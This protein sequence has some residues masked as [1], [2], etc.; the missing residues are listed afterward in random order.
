MLSKVSCIIRASIKMIGFLAW[1]LLCALLQIPVMLLS[2]NRTSYV[3]PRLY[4]QGVCK[5]LN[6]KTQIIGTISTEKRLYLSNHLSYLDVPV[7]GSLIPFVSFVAK[8][9]VESWPAFGA[10]AKLQR[11]FFIDR[12]KNA[13]KTESARFSKTLR[14][15]K[16][17]ILFPE[18]TSGRG[19][20]VKTL[21][22][23][24]FE[25]FKH[26]T[27]SIFFVQPVTIRLDQI[28][29]KNVEKDD[30]FDHYAWHLDEPSF[31]VHLWRFMQQKSAN[32][33]IIFHDSVPV[34]G[35]QSRKELAEFYHTIINKPLADRSETYDLLP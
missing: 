8:K 20:H 26:E 14:E 1:S 28:N 27:D 29:G 11:T 25:M 30:D 21:K 22:S 12:A 5:I 23:P 19:R 17:L 35:V 7:L 10:L 13:I 32:L 15:E 2:K 16:S 31:V 18:G 4:H 24:L 34:D 9:E 3:L 6:I 33:S